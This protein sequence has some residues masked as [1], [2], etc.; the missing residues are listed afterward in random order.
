MR[1]SLYAATINTVTDKKK[2]PMLDDCHSLWH[3]LMKVAPLLNDPIKHGGLENAD[4]FLC[5]AP[6]YG[7][8][9]FQKM[10]DGTKNISQKKRDGPRHI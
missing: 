1:V 5:L 10:L 3:R 9:L 6:H 7:A 8:F 2:S 4:I